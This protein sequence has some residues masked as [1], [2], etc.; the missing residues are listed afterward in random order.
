[1]PPASFLVCHCAG[2][3][4][5]LV[6]PGS[7]NYPF[8]IDKLR[9]FPKIVSIWIDNRM[10]PVKSDSIIF[11]DEILH[12]KGS[13]H[14]SVVRKRTQNDWERWSSW[15]FSCSW[16]GIPSNDITT[17]SLNFE[18]SLVDFLNVKIHSFPFWPPKHGVHVVF[19]SPW[20]YETLPKAA[21]MNHGI[22]V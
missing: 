4:N 22:F 20:G 1:M 3:R 13:R 18:L 8:C 2:G 15:Q 14:Q 16:Y 21:W 17:I 11:C 9:D 12:I 19:S 5:L 6:K 7:L 10:T